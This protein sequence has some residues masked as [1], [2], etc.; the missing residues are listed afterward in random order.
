MDDYSSDE[1]E[2]GEEEEL[3]YFTDEEIISTRTSKCFPK[4]IAL[5]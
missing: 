2:E 5:P 1:E 3:S 4:Q